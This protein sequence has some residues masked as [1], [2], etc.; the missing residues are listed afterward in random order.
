MLKNN[1]LFYILNRD[2]NYQLNIIYMY[3]FKKFNFLKIY[4]KSELDIILRLNGCIKNFLSSVFV[5]C[6]EMNILKILKQNL[7]FKAV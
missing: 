3:S 2:P 7:T 6:N 4:W 5:M 1:K